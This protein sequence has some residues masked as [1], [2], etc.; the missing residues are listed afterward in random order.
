MRKVSI[1]TLE[2]Q[3]LAK[4]KLLAQLGPCIHGSLAKIAVTCGKPNCKCA[5]GD[6]HTAHILTRKVRGKSQSLYLPVDIVEE[7]RLW[8]QQHRLA[9]RLLR[10]ISLL[11]E[12]I[13]RAHVPSKRARQKN[14]AARRPP[15]GP[16]P[17][18]P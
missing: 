15:H 17:I 1:A 18:P 10:Q 14:L 11:S 16:P 5:T 6:K 12:Q 7:V 8:S 13:I 2:V 4:L 9:K 3:R